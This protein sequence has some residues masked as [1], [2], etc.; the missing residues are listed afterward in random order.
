MYK[1]WE[2]KKDRFSARNVLRWLKKAK[3]WQLVLL[4]VLMGFIVA[5]F[6]RLNNIGMIQK[7]DAVLAADKKLDNANTKKELTELQSYVSSHMNSDMGKGILL[8][9]TYQRD[10]DVAVAAAADSHNSNSDLYQKA[11]LDCRA[12]FH[13]GVASFRNDYVTCVANAVSQLSPNQQSAVLPHLEDYHYNFA[14]PLIS[15]DLAGFFVLISLVL[16]LFIL[17]RLILL[18]SLRFI[19]KRRAKVL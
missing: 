8:Q 5:T 13:G 12:R 7:R 19:I 15:P 18:Y 16:T 2:P 17:L 4:L 14:S 9:N 6:L 3:T 11:A 1:R 10:Y